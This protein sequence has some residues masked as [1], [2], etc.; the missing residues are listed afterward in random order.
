M[1][2]GEPSR[3]VRS[4]S[5]HPLACA[6]VSYSPSPPVLARSRPNM[7]RPDPHSGRTKLARSSVTRTV[8]HTRPSRRSSRLSLVE[9]EVRDVPT[10][11]GNQLF[12][13][14]NPWNQPIADAPVSAN[15]AAII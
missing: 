12:P 6:R 10:F 8:S 13:L 2:R 15:S 4:T 5:T 3:G 14:D 7:R 11:Y 1:G 9:L